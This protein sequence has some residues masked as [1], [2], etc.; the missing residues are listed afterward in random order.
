[1]DVFGEWDSDRFQ[2]VLNSVLESAHRADKSV[3]MLALDH[4]DIHRW[5]E[6]GVDFLISGADMAYLTTGSDAS[7]EEFKKTT[8]EFDNNE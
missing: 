8:R 3:G 1:M 7:R 4:D 5:V 6:G 2:S